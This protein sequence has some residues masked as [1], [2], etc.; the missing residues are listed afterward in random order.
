MSCPSKALRQLAHIQD[1]IYEASKAEETE[2]RE[3]AQLA[4]A[5]QRL[6]EQKR[7][8][9]MKPAPKPQDVGLAKPRR[10][11]GNGNSPTLLPTDNVTPGQ[12]SATPTPPRSD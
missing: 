2:N 9:K 5:W 1:I 11:P 4:C 10:R 7:I 6:E 8:L 12:P 3:L